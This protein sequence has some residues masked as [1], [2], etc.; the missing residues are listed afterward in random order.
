MPVR[1]LPFW[2]AIAVHAGGAPDDVD[3]AK[4]FH[5]SL[6]GAG[7]RDPVIGLGC[8]NCG[9]TFNAYEDELFLTVRDDG[10]PSGGSVWGSVF[11]RAC[12]AS[13]GMMDGK[14]RSDA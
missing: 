1:L 10:N 7:Q 8:S 9:G 5:R 6:L 3:A 13:T 2:S 4:D 11:C 12:A 14:K